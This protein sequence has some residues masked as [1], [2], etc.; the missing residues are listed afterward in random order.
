MSGI[1]GWGWLFRDVGTIWFNAFDTGDY[2][3]PKICST[4]RS[5]GHTHSSVYGYGLIDDNGELLHL[6]DFFTKAA[7]YNGYMMLLQTPYD[8]IRGEGMSSSDDGFYFM[9]LGSSH[10]SYA[11]M[12]KG[13]WGG[14]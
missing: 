13:Y 8:C 4:D 9:C 2:S 7:G 10:Y 14:S 11:K 5:D 6:G 3:N 12:K 1:H